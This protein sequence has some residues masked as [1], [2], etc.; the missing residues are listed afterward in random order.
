MAAKPKKEVPSAVCEA[1]ADRL[2]WLRARRTG[3]GAS[4][5]AAVLGVS[6]WSSPLQVFLSKL[7]E[8]QEAMSERME[9]GLR[10][11]PTIAEAFAA[12]TGRVVVAPPPFSLYRNKGCPWLT[13]SID[14]FQASGERHDP[15]VLEIKCTDVAADWETEPP[16]YYQVQVQHE[17]AVTGLRWASL[18]V[19]I[20]GNR[21]LRVDVERNDAFIAELLK[22][23]EAFWKVVQSREPPPPGP[24]DKDTLKA[25][26][27]SDSGETIALPA[28]VDEWLDERAS[29]KDQI[30]ALG[31]RLDHVENSI[32]GL[33]QNATRGIL[34]GGRSVSWKAEDVKEH[35]V[36]AFTRR[37]LRVHEVRFK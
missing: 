31:E 15:G 11:E 1:H 12:K 25:M 19:L 7:S 4:D 30:A 24:L 17:L 36:P 5:A 10:H 20:R 8:P 29:L 28:D 9:W 13:A 3:I 27:P 34:P 6:P 18:C 37:V 22:Q 21:M 26:Y 14:R 2:S 16:I 33:L 32:K 35:I 23:E